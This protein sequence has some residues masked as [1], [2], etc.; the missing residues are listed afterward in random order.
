MQELHIG[1][2]VIVLNNR[3]QVLLGKRLSKHGFG[4]WSFPGGHLEAG[5]S[6]F[7]CAQREVQEETGLKLTNSI[8]GPSVQDVFAQ[9]DKHYLTW[10]VIAKAEGVPQV[11]EPEKCEGWRWFDW[12]ELPE[13]LF[14]PIQTLMRQ[15]FKLENYKI[16]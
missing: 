14:Q 13:P 15:G 2:G 9:T 1:V 16:S 6:P 11:L 4:T 3:G 7:E 10:F 5:E 8:L 12:A